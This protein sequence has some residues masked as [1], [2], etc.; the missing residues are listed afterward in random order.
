MIEIK[1]KK[2][3]Y[4]LPKT[5]SIGDWDNTGHIQGI[6]VD[7]EKGY[8]YYSMTTVFVKSDL[9]GNI[10]GYVKGL[11]GHLGCIS[12]NREDGKVY[13]SLE[14]KHDSIGSG[15]MKR[16]GAVLADEDAFY[17]AIF[18][19]DKIDRAELDAERDG[20]MTAVYLPEVIEDYS[21]KNPD[22]T[23]HRYGCSGV[24]GT[25]IGPVP[26]DLGGRSM[27]FMAYGIYGTTERTD[28]E[29]QVI[30]QFDWRRFDKA[31][32]PLSQ[33]APHH[34]GLYS[35]RRM[36]LYTGNTSWGIQNLEYDPYTGDYIAAVYKGKKPGFPN[37]PMFIIDGGKAPEYREI[38]GRAGE[39]GYMLTLKKV[40]ESHP[41]GICGLNFPYGQ[42]G[43]F[44]VGDGRYYFSHDFHRLKE[45]GGKLFSSDIKLYTFD[46]ETFKLM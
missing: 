18:D 24:D 4:D 10:V 30:M 7:L 27:L 6:A 14:Y 22:G 37:Y 15:I 41:S 26:G 23:A 20:I 31:A 12:F 1:K 36:F 35:D 44:A 19:V 45:D 9:S 28:S 32:K 3:I 34:S 43:I 2:K 39:G 38:P 13:G 46:G 8:I 17:I 11:T 21:A 29:N 40:G 25:A 33:L 42:T 5:I 16:T